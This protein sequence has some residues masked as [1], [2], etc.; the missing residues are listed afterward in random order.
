MNDVAQRSQPHNQK[1]RFSHAAPCAQNRSSY[2]WNDPLGL[3]QSRFEFPAFQTSRVRAHFQPCNRCLSHERLAATKRAMPTTAVLKKAPRSPQREPEPPVG[4]AHFHPVRAGP[5]PSG[6][7]RSRPHSRRQPEYRLQLSRHRDTEYVQHEAYR[8]NRLQT[9]PWR[10]CAEVLPKYRAELP[11][12][13]SF[14]PYSAFVKNPNFLAESSQAI[15]PESPLPFHVSLQPDRPRCSLH[16][17]LRAG[18]RH[19][20]EPA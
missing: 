8:S 5:V 18:S 7:R 11:C 12:Q 2:A 14:R 9:Q 15:P 4:R 17:P 3:R 13:Q 1:L 19:L 6:S 10:R 16:V 20:P